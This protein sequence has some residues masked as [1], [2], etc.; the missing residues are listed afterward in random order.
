MAK[1][2]FDKYYTPPNVARF[3]INK[4]FEI[5]GKENISEIIEPSAGC[6]MFSFQLDCKAYDLYP[7][8]ELIE[9]QDFL[10]LDLGYKK[11]RLFIGNP[12]F[13][14]TG[15][16]ITKFYNKCIKEG[17]YIAFLLPGSQYKNYNSFHKFE[18]IYSILIETDYTNTKLITA[19]NIYKRNPDKE[20][21]REPKIQ[22]KDFTLKRFERN[23]KGKQKTIKMD[24]DYCFSTFGFPALKPSK[25]Y[26]YSAGYL[27]KINNPIL[28]NQIIECLKFLYHWGKKTKF[29]EKT[30]IS[31]VSVKKNDIQKLLKI[32]IPELK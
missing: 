24:Y 18:I 7:Q 30:K 25:P 2:A 28:K 26:Q 6:G 23:N 31:S 20:D 1:I 8:N 14:S 9:Q 5:I 27:I 16:L 17:D 12:P 10:Q 4:T 3:C 11:G 21:F 13:G 22:Y 32:C 15:G 29:F 19:F